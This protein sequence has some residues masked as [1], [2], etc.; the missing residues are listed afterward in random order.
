MR[1]NVF[2]ALAGILL[3][4]A[5]VSSAG[6]VT[7]S[8]DAR[9]WYYESG[10]SNGRLAENNTFTGFNPF[11][12]DVNSWFGFD[13][14]G[15]SGTVTAAELVLDVAGYSS[16]DASEVLLLRHVAAPPGQLG[17]VDSVALFEDLMTGPIFGTRAFGAA[18]AGE[19]RPILLEAAGVADINAA[20]GGYWEVGG[21]ISTLSRTGPYESIFWGAYG[22]PSTTQLR[23]TTV[24]EPATLLVLAFGLAVVVRRRR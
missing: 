8:A 22:D 23:L 15:L 17:T 2:G 14:S 24:P 16:P 18:D 1:W 12:N 10:L 7:L 5:G 21:H 3:A 9:G 19:M 4:G 6:V 13:L 20:A 11:A